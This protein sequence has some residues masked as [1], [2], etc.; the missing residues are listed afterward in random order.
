MALWLTSPSLGARDGWALNGRSECAE[1]ASRNTSRDDFQLWPACAPRCHP[2]NWPAV[3]QHFPYPSEVAASRPDIRSGPM[4]R[5]AARPLMP[6]DGSLVLASAFVPPG[7]GPSRLLQVAGPSREDFDSHRTWLP[8]L[9]HSS[10]RNWTRS[11]QLTRQ[12][13]RPS[14]WRSHRPKE[15]TTSLE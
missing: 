14:R 10:A 3:P 12:L 7:L 9:G 11:A 2:V 4:L 15:S 1:R 5:M 13:P 6:H 8:A